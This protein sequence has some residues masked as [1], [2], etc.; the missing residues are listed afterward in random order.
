MDIVFAERHDTCQMSDSAELGKAIVLS[1]P[2][3]Q[4]HSGEDQRRASRL[5]TSNVLAMKPMG[6]APVGQGRGPHVRARH[7]RARRRHDRIRGRMI[8]L[9]LD[10]PALELI[11][12]GAA[13]IDEPDV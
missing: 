13:Q 8:S 4:V 6:V 5:A 11:D 7:A 12:S 9:T 2:Y 1:R 10:K 3:V